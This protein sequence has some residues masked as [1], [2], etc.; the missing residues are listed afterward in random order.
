MIGQKQQPLAFAIAVANPPQSFGVSLLGV[1][2]DQLY[3]LP[4]NR[5]RAA[6][7]GRRV[8]VFA[9]EI[10]F[11]A[12]KEEALALMGGGRAA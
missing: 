6:I 9:F 12:G 4:A 8:R 11:S 5:A 2:D 3:F 1:K 10:G 7:E